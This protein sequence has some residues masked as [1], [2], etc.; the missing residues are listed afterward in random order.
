MSETGQ[1]SKAEHDAV[2]WMHRIGG[3]S[4]DQYLQLPE[5]LARLLEENRNEL[6]AL[7][8]ENARLREVAGEL[9]DALSELTELMDDVRAAEYHPDSFTNQPARAALAKAKEVLG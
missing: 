1:I 4:P 7:R 8:A 2:Q 3:F 5:K 6:A 9:R